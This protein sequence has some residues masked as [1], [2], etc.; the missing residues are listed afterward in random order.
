MSR[1]NAN[2]FDDPG[3]AVVTQGENERASGNFTDAIA[4]FTSAIT[5]FTP[6][7]PV[8]AVV[9]TLICRGVAYGQLGQS[10]AAIEDFSQAIRLNPMRELAYFNRGYTFERQGDFL[11]AVEDYGRAIELCSTKSDYYLHRCLCRKR[12]GDLGGARSD[13]ATV[14]QLRQRN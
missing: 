8:A 5:D 4:T 14:R 11:Q 2:S 9:E 10:K 1:L 6:D 13:F 3:W 12:L 7:S